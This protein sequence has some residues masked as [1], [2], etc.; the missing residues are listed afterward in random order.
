MC[1]RIIFLNNEFKNEEYLSVLS[2]WDGDGDNINVS[3]IVFCY[4]DNVIVVKGM[5]G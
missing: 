5:V 4:F 2:I 3:L 1:V